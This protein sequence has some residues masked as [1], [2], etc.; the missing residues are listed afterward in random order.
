MKQI[1]IIFGNQRFKHFYIIFGNVKGP[2][3]GIG[4]PNYFLF[5]FI[6]CKP[7]RFSADNLLC[8]LVQ[9]STVGFSL[10]IFINI[11]LALAQN[12]YYFLLTC[13]YSS[14]VYVCEAYLA[15]SLS[16]VLV[17]L[18]FIRSGLW[19]LSSRLPLHSFFDENPAIEYNGSGSTRV[20]LVHYLA[21]DIPLVLESMALC[22]V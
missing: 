20:K 1:Y 17:I 13:P 4:F 19:Q 21:S 8:I 18:R 12:L 11:S 9:R 2:T 7:R 14:G 22:S 15:D 5:L 3:L 10:P 6:S 16:F